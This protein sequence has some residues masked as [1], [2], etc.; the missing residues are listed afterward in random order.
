MRQLSFKIGLIA[1]L[2]LAAFSTQ[3]M[4][5]RGRIER[6]GQYGVYPVANVSVTLSSSEGRTTPSFTDSSGIYYF[7]NIPAGV[8]LLEVWIWGW[9]IKQ[10][11]I[12]YTI[13]VNK[14]YTDIKTIRI[15]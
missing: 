15:P 5:V 1:V 10:E 4:T 3:A 12:L 9:R 2:A 11:P 7:Y 6:A 13:E 14:P 8:Y